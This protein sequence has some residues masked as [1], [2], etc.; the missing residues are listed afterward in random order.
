MQRPSTRILIAGA[1]AVAAV[2]LIAVIALA[3]RRD[4]DDEQPAGR[5]IGPS[6]VATPTAETQATSTAPASPQLT[7][8][9]TATPTPT[10]ATPT[11][12][13]TAT[14]S[15]A[16]MP[17][18]AATPAPTTA[19][20]APRR[21][22]AAAGETITVQS[23]VWYVDPRSGA[24][25]GWEIPGVTLS[26]LYRISPGGRYIAYSLPGPQGRPPLRWQLLDTR[27]GAVREIGG[28]PLFAPD[29]S[30]FV[31]PTQNGFEVVRSAD[32]A[33][34]RT[35]PLG[36]FAD[37]VSPL[38][39]GAWSPS[40]DTLLVWFGDVPLGGLPATRVYRLTVA[41]GAAKEVARRPVRLGRWFPDGRRYS[42]LSAVGDELE[43]RDAG[44]DRVLWSQTVDR[45]FLAE[46][47]PRPEKPEG[48]L[49]LPSFSPDGRQAAIIARWQPQQPP[50]AQAQSRVLVVDPA[51]GGVRFWVEGAW[52]CGP[53]RWTADGRWLLVQGR[54]GATAGAFLVSADGRQV[55]YLTEHVED[56]SPTDAS[57]AGL[58]TGGPA[59]LFLRVINVPDGR[60]RQEIRLNGDPGWDFAHDPLW[61]N[62]GRMVVT[63][64]HGGHGGCA[65]GPAP[66]AEIAVRFP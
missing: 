26:A 66:A 55:Q 5:V 7:P 39:Y 47:A 44:D 23:G 54:R 32:G 9:T 37:P 49:T 30:R 63:G 45:F 48:D 31:V 58:L 3:L 20:G 17:T 15:P 12:T 43:V 18:A 52:A 61:L 42:L 56:L 35:F 33:V 22:T 60:I 51:T 6:V 34:E 57:I 28:A 65:E 36:R 53:R 40:G 1:A 13:A 50:G 38:P 8:T 10:P 21:L 25:E 64:P 27:T 19:A 41:D 29:E 62:D 2:L 14:A 11:A 46:G 59:G 24:A 16:G 4:N